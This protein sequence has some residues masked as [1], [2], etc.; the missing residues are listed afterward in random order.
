MLN[1]RSSAIFT[2]R[3]SLEEQQTMN[4]PIVEEVRWFRK[5][6]AAQHGNDVNRIAAA[7]RKK[8]QASEKEYLNPGPKPLRKKP[9]DLSSQ[10]V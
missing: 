2:R 1:L 9:V 10:K 7:L 5:E 3:K 4:D 6:H 8:E